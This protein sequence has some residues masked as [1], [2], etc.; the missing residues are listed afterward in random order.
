MRGGLVDHLGNDVPLHFTAFHPDWRMLDVPPTP[1][2]TLH[3][4]RGIALAN[5]V[6]YAYTGNVIDREGGTTRCAVCSAPLIVRAGYEIDGWGLD[7]AG[8][9]EKC[10]TRCAGVFEAGHGRWGSRRQPVRLKEYGR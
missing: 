6:R 8:C 7:A 9:C 2:S 5:G 1:P 3:R 10:G 4:A